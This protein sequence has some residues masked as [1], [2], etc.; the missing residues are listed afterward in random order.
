LVAPAL[1]ASEL[2]AMG[3][4]L[5]RVWRKAGVVRLDAMA[6]GT[7]DGV[8]A[9]LRAGGMRLLPFDHFGNW[10]LA[11]IADWNT[12]LAARPGQLRT[13]IG[14]YTKRLMT[15][16][17]AEFRLVTSADELESGIAAY[18]KIYAASWKEPEPF[19]RFNA[20]LMRACATEGSLRLGLILANGAP[21]AVQF[22]VLRDGCAHV[23]KLA[24]D[25]AWKASAPGTVLSA[26][27]IRHL[28]EIDGA[29]ALDFGRGDDA[30][31]QLWTGTRRQRVGALVASP[32]SLGGGSAIA[33][34][35]VKEALLFF[36]KRTNVPRG[37]L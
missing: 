16:G 4:A 6:Q 12:Y 37:R 3:R 20:T 28:L 27:M 15:G 24:H 34:E 18:E 14:R 32:W 5:A 35:G 19:P 33:R 1:D 30:Y 21:V 11:D 22:W 7:L 31:K 9:G 23:L 10:Y 17:G 2:A 29:R 36:K 26:L 13:A 25:E 8:A